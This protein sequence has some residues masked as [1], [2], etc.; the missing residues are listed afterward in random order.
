MLFTM[1]FRKKIYLCSA[2]VILL[3]FMVSCS[4]SPRYLKNRNIRYS[5][6]LRDVRVLLLKT[7]DRVTISS[8]T[9]TRVKEIKTG[10]VV[11]DSGRSSLRITPDRIKTPIIIE[12]WNSPLA[13]DG[14]PY[15]GS[16]EVHNVL[17]NICVINIVSMN[18]Y[19][20]SVVP[21][22]IPSTWP[23]ETLKCQAVAART[24]S[25]YHILN[26][27]KTDIFD[28]DATT[29]SQVYTGVK[30]EKPSTS[31]AVEDTEGIIIT[32]KNQPIVAYFHSTCGGNTADDKFVWQGYDHQYLK[33]VTCSYCKESPYFSW[34]SYLDLYEI[35]KAVLKKYRNIDRITN[36]AFSKKEGRVIEVKIVHSNGTI[37]LTGNEFRLLFPPKT[38][39]SL[40]F[41]SDKK[42]QGL[43]LHGHGW[44]HGVGM[45]QWGARGMAM[46]GFDYRSILD[47]YYKNTRLVRIKEV[48][49]R[50]IA[51]S[52]RK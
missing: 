29:R 46:K 9:R 41:T 21:S 50:S 14:V 49:N 22:E 5:S 30:A 45:C 36:I 19:L 31:K 10:R 2:A 12:S 38:V 44:G 47:Y 24:Y 28:L 16:I 3:G 11:F 48:P 20:K 27:T 18:D 34:D 40:Y 6:E 13:L 43:Q 15:R 8:G 33:S 32:E 52:E 17:G 51:M 42:G 37:R 1:S 7:K 4:P 35:K 26:G 23:M 39:K 25:Y